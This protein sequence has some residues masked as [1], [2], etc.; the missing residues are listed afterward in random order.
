V[1]VSG[2]TYAFTT[3]RSPR[4]AEHRGESFSRPQGSL[5]EKTLLLTD[6]A[7]STSSLRRFLHG[8]FDYRQL[9]T[10][11][12]RALDVIDRH[13]EIVVVNTMQTR[14]SRRSIPD[15]F[16][17]CTLGGMLDQLRLVHLPGE[18][19]VSQERSRC[20]RGTERVPHST[21]PTRSSCVF[22]LRAQPGKLRYLRV[23]P[24][25]SARER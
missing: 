24:M 2:G 18:P 3:G 10:V 22:D 9:P 5:N 14:G 17:A 8:R 15:W 7:H 13:P 16:W 12:G 1:G 19:K 11:V 23:E 21:L 6:R 25:M 4:H 20:R